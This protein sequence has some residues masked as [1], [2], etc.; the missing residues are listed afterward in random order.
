MFVSDFAYDIFLQ[1]V[2]GLFVIYMKYIHKN[3]KFSD[4]II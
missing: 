4:I 1:D 3:I 2:F